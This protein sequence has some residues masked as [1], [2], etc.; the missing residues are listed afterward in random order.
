VR[1][2]LGDLVIG[3]VG[4][5]SQD[6]AEIGEWIKAAPTAVFNDRVDDGAALAGIGIAD[7]KPVFLAQCRWADGI[8]HKVIVYALRRRR[9]SPGEK[10]IPAGGIAPARSAE[11][12]S[13]GDERTEIPSEKAPLGG[14]SVNV[15]CNA[16]EH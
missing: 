3:H 2:D 10:K 16:S 11:G 6:V 1:C 13:G 15:G 7:E 14:V 5:A 9:G 8:F 12:G 4:Q